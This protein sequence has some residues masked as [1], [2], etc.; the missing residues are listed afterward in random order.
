MLHQ[1]HIMSMKQ[2]LVL[3]AKNGHFNYAC[4]DCPSSTPSV[5]SEDNF[6]NRD[7]T[8]STGKTGFYHLNVGNHSNSDLDSKLEL[9]F[10]VNTNSKSSPWIRLDNQST[11][12]VFHSA[13]LLT[14]ISQVDASRDLP[15]LCLCGFTHILS[16]IYCLQVK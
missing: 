6:A 5:P 14:N 12:D 11:V 8:G 13:R 1:D 16:T 9:S 3:I 4:S 7:N 2:S 10:L 15:G